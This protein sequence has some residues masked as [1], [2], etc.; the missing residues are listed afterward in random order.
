VSIRTKLVKSVNDVIR[1]LRVQLVPGTSPDP[2]IKDYI[3]ARKTI[4][5]AQKAGLSG[6]PTEEG[7]TTTL[8]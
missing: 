5:A 8:R 1:P 2:A 6:H 4:A 3:P 7:W